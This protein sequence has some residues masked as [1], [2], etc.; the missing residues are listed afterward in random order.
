MAIVIWWPRSISSRAIGSTSDF[1]EL[2]AYNKTGTLFQLCTEERLHSCQI[3]WPMLQT[4]CHRHPDLRNSAVVYAL[5]IYV[6]P[7]LHDYFVVISLFRFCCFVQH[8]QKHSRERLTKKMSLFG[9][10][11]MGNSPARPAAQRML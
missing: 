5:I 9:V 7:L 11:T 3:A 6:L 1:N 8:Q 2:A 10:S 4:S